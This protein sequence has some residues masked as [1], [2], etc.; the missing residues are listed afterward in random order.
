MAWRY[1]AVREDGTG[2]HGEILDGDLPL[3]DVSITDVLSGPPQLTASIEPEYRKLKG[4]DGKPLLQQWGTAVFAEEDDHIIGGGILVDSRFAGAQWQLDVSGYCGYPKDMPYIDS[5]FGVGI[6][7]LNVVRQIWTHVQG[8]PN[9]NIGLEVDA[10]TTTP[11]RIGTT[12]K[13]V[14][15]DTQSGP[16][17]FESGPVKL[18]WWETLD[19][20]GKMDDL[21]RETPFD[22]HERHAWVGDEI[23]HYLD[24]GYPRLG[25][26]LN[27]LR[28]VYGE[29]VFTPPEVDG[30]GS[31]Y[32]SEILGVG[33]GEGRTAVRTIHRRNTG[34][35]R[36]AVS[37]EN[38]AA[39]SLKAIDAYVKSE[40]NWRANQES[41]SEL[42]LVDHPHAPVGSVKPGDEILFE[43][44]LGWT[45]LS[46][47]VRVISV[48]TTPA[49]PDVQ[50]L[51]VL[52][53]DRIGR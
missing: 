38:K 15:F 10:T 12:L 43:G 6:D 52:P 27:G 4:S 5:W 33:A 42:V 11:V 37:V 2:G 29:N 21:A 19:L 36:R 35:L 16:V 49:S 17:S 20:A 1:L 45:D 31:I 28:F 32:A 53:T 14:E 24:F 7:P 23:H 25:T 39:R 41:I 30:G 22:Y 3:T 34:R 40:M 48:T 47:Y 13:Q 44:D 26:R 8:Q 51:Q 46:M 18:N 9:G 50:R